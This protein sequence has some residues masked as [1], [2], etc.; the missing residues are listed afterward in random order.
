LNGIIEADETYI[1]GK[2]R[3]KHHYAVRPG[4]RIQDVL[5]PVADKQA[6]F[7]VME[8]GGRVH[9]RHVEKVTADNLRGVLND[10]ASQDAHLMTD[11]GVL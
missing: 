9:S 5:G 4:R 10:V 2:R 6:V 8:R 1:G 3:N 11:T 7:S